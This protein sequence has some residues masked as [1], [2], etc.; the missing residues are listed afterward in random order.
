MKLARLAIAVAIAWPLASIA[1]AAFAQ[2]PTPPDPNRRCAVDGVRVV[3]ADAGDTS[4]VEIVA[5]VRAVE[6]TNTPCAIDWTLVTLAAPN[7]SGPAPTIAF[8]QTF[9]DHQLTPPLLLAD[10]VSSASLRPWNG[11][12]DAA[13]KVVA[14]RFVIEGSSGGVVLEVPRAAFP[15]RLVD[16]ARV[17]RRVKSARSGMAHFGALGE[18]PIVGSAPGPAGGVGP[19]SPFAASAERVV[20]DFVPHAGDVV[21]LAWKPPGAKTLDLFRDVLPRR[22]LELSSAAD[23]PWDEVAREAYAAS[24]HGDPLVASLG[25]HTLAW[26]GGG[27]A[28]QPI[29]IAKTAGG[30]DVAVVPASVVDAIGDVEARLHKRWGAVGRL[31]PLGRPSVF[32]KALTAQPWLD[33]ALAK[34]AKQSVARLATVD[35]STL[36]AH[37]TPAIVDVSA[38][39][40]PPGPVVVV[41]SMPNAPS[42]TPPSSSVQPTSVGPTL[43]AALLTAGSYERHR[44]RVRWARVGLA[45]LAVAGIAYWLRRNA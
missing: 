6:V 5:R 2:D 28:L 24:L 36:A 26:L 40:D 15:T 11:E 9:V 39:V 45:L 19:T 21:A 27:L 35:A 14:I 4:V 1:P 12:V 13:G 17:E 7:E 38:P 32:R 3:V 31:L 29:K 23:G 44:R 10:G 41:G 25:V 16:G 43:T 18:I 30:T 37:I 33:G 34:A 8:A 22:V 42:T 20:V